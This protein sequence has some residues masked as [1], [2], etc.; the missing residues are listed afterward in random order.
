M[1]QLTHG[2]NKTAMELNRFCPKREGDAGTSHE[3]KSIWNVEQQR[4]TD[5]SNIIA[6]IILVSFS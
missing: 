2:K 5:T 3:K 6:N 1:N 4:I